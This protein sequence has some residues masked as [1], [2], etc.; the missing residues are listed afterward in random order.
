[1]LEGRGDQ[2]ES[3]CCLG[4]KFLRFVD[5]RGNCQSCRDEY[6]DA[7]LSG[8]ADESLGSIG[9]LASGA[10]ESLSAPTSTHDGHRYAD[11]GGH[12]FDK[13]RYWGDILCHLGDISGVPYYQIDTKF[14]FFLIS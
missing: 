11:I 1:M 6:Y 2:Y 12:D 10:A 3:A 7:N 4:R 5:L 14:L 9:V 13:T 8:R